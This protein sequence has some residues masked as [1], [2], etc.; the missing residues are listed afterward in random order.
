MTPEGR[1]WGYSKPKK[2]KPSKKPKGGKRSRPRR[3]GRGKN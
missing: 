3:S 1:P 2:P